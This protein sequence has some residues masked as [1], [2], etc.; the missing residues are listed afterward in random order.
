MNLWLRECTVSEIRRKS[1][2]LMTDVTLSD[3]EPE[4]AEP[5]DGGV[6]LTHDRLSEK[7][8][9][10]L[11]GVAHSCGLPVKVLVQSRTNL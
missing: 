2:P 7:L 10:E 4:G 1:F 3:L 5:V 11:S 6:L 9:M 8:G